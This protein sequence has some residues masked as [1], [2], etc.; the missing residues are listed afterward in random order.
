[1]LQW[2]RANGYPWAEET[3]SSAAWQGH[4]DILQWARANG[5]PWDE[6]TC[7]NAAWDGH[8]G[9]LQWAHENGCPWN[10]E[11]CFFVIPHVRVEVL[12]YLHARTTA[13]SASRCWNTCTR[14]RLPRGRTTLLKAYILVYARYTSSIWT[15]WHAHARAS[16]NAVGE[17]QWVNTSG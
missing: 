14:E 2:L 5:C 3:C 10:A 12:E 8:L 11:A 7:T 13:Q 9:V 1:M 16:V 15:R 17:Y 6:K 4:L